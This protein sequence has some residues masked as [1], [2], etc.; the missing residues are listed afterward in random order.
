MRR[1]PLT[2]STQSVISFHTQS[3]AA[4]WN[5]QWLAIWNRNSTQKSSCVDFPQNSQPA[6]F[7]RHC[8]CWGLSLSC[9]LFHWMTFS[10]AWSSTQVWRRL[11]AGWLTGSLYT[12]DYLTR[13]LE[14][15]WPYQT[16]MMGQFEVWPE[17]FH[18]RFRQRS[19]G[20]V[21]S[22]FRALKT[23]QMTGE[24]CE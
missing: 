17:W 3:F 8:F 10:E 23:T 2:Q 11:L 21:I 19:H 22:H 13:R 6:T 12:R 5:P 14:N 24:A 16:R 20:L 4:C 18:R 1:A 15:T 7:F 9:L